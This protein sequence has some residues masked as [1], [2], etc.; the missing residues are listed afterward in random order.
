[1][2]KKN[3]YPEKLKKFHF[4]FKGIWI[5]KPKISISQNFYKYYLGVKIQIE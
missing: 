5:F 1:M 2:Q 3:P 4:Y